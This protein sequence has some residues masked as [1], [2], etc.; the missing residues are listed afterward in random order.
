VQEESAQAQEGAQQPLDQLKR[1]GSS[2]GFNVQRA[3]RRG[4]D[5]SC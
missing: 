2:K 4:D 3:H 1:S 5:L